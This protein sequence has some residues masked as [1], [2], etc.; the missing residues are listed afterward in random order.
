MRDDYF[1]DIKWQ[2]DV[3]DSIISGARPNIDYKA[4]L[5]FRTQVIELCWQDDPE[6]RPQMDQVL[7]HLLRMSNNSK[8]YDQVHAEPQ[9]KI[10]SKKHQ[11]ILKQKQAEA[12]K[13]NNILHRELEHQQAFHNKINDSS[14]MKEEEDAIEEKH[15][16]EFRKFTIGKNEFPGTTSLPKIPK[17]SNELGTALSD[18]GTSSLAKIPTSLPKIPKIKSNEPK[19]STT[20]KKMKEGKIVTTVITT[21][22]PT[23]TMTTVKTSTT[24][25]PQDSR[26]DSGKRQF[27]Q[28]K[29]QAASQQQFS[30]Q[31][32]KLKLG[33]S[34]CK[35]CNGV[36]TGNDSRFCKFCGE[37]YK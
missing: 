10:Q 1:G 14:S 25:K 30:K 27:S 24:P 13:N 33:K 23:G 12:E 28:Q 3:E 35:T 32:K 5:G 9:F 26:T 37:L 16:G 11:E 21:K 19:S 29:L 7:T 22:T 6:L 4:P 31:S 15:S 17:I 36:N 20:T 8:V 2:C 18:F 34:I